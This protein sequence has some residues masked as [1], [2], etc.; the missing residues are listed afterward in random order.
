MRN[1]QYRAWQSKDVPQG[2]IRNANRKFRKTFRT[3]RGIAAIHP[4]FGTMDATGW[5]SIPPKITSRI[6]GS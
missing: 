4:V 1:D 2:R 3:R 5:P 6:R